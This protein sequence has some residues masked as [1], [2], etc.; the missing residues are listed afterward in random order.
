MQAT[1]TF[2]SFYFDSS[3]EK[4]LGSLFDYELVKAFLQALCI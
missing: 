1:I 2:Q 4:P 3:I